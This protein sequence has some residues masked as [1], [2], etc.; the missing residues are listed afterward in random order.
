MDRQQIA[1]D[2]LRLVYYF[3]KRYSYMLPDWE[4]DDLVGE[5]MLIYWRAVLDWDPKRGKLSTLVGESI[6]RKFGHHVRKYHRP[7]QEAV[8]DV[9]GPDGKK[10][11]VLDLLPAG[12]DMAQEV[13][14]SHVFAQFY[15][16]LGPR[17]RKIVAYRCQ[18]MS[19][20]EIG[21][22]IGLSQGNVSRAL[23]RIRREAVYQEAV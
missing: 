1:E 13:T 15:E 18:E 5:G 16:T 12:G 7:V 4:W 22:R 14:D 21:R 20:E 10:V 23:S 17:D 2:N 3:C 19:Q 6:R 11:N 9:T 8:V